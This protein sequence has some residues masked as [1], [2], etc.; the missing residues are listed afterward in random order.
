MLGFEFD[1]STISTFKVPS[2]FPNHCN[3]SHHLNDIRMDSLFYEKIVLLRFG[4]ILVLSK[5]YVTEK[6]ICL[7]R[8]IPYYLFHWE[9]IL[10]HRINLSMPSTSKS[11][12][13]RPWA[14]SIF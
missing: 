5:F 14:I 1:S 6:P 2:F 7:E 3:Y 13:K 8:T 4:F 10:L 12:N 9:Y 11:T